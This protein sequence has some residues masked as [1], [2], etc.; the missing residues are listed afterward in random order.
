MGVV[1]RGGNTCLT[2]GVEPALESHQKSLDPYVGMRDRLQPERA[3]DGLRRRSIRITR[4]AGCNGQG[5]AGCEGKGCRQTRCLRREVCEMQ[6]A[7]NALGIDRC[8]AGEPHTGKLGRG[9]RRGRVGKAHPP[10]WP[11]AGPLP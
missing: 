11:L 7:N 8:F 6:I 3:T 5:I 10:G 2:R 4:S 9:V 1:V